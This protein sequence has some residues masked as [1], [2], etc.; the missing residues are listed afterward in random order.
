MFL[1]PHFSPLS[2]RFWAVG[3]LAL[4][5]AGGHPPQRPL[6][7]PR[8]S[9]RAP[10]ARIRQDAAE[11]NIGKTALARSFGIFQESAAADSRNAGCLRDRRQDARGERPDLLGRARITR[12]PAHCVSHQLIFRAKVD[13][14]DELNLAEGSQENFKRRH[15][16][17]V[18]GAF[19]KVAAQHHR[20]RREAGHAMRRRPPAPGGE[21]IG[22]GA[23]FVRCHS[24]EGSFD[25]FPRRFV[26]INGSERAGRIPL[27]RDQDSRGSFDCIVHGILLTGKKGRSETASVKQVI[28]PCRPQFP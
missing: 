25:A 24:F 4:P 5:C 22:V 20:R 10:Q 21:R 1:S 19:E 26:G 15:T 17:S 16:G 3:P 28:R 11:R 23:P 2:Y 6:E 9:F 7:N 8:R 27:E 18:L 14:S 13:A 12:Q